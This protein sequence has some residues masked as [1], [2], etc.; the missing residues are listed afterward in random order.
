MKVT[1]LCLFGGTLVS[2]GV[3]MQAA[4]APTFEF[5]DGGYLNGYSYVSSS[6][7][8]AG[9]VTY[10]PFLEYAFDGYLV[11]VQ[12]AGDDLN[13]TYTSDFGGSSATTIRTDSLLRVEQTWDGSNYWGYAGAIIQQFFTV[14]EDTVLEFT[15]DFSGTDFWP[16]TA[17]IL[18]EVSTGE[19]E[20][21]YVDEDNPA[22]RV[23]VDLEAGVEY[24]LVVDGGTPFVKNTEL[25]WMQARLIP[26]PGTAG[27]LALGGLAAV[28]R[29]R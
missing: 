9:Y 19:L 8:A 6:F 18:T 20:Y 13:A 2:A 27:L 4:A 23:T 29:R 16:N 10:D 22:G 14:A 26:A 28:R 24:A 25:Q 11:E 21:T 5:I 15:W 12:A 17:F 3:A 7:V 1:K